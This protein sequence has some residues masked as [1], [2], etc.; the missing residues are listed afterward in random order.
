MECGIVTYA[1]ACREAAAYLP[2]VRRNDLAARLRDLAE[3][4]DM[5]GLADTDWQ[6]E[7]TE[8]TNIACHLTAPLSDP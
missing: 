8:F 4:L 2:D 5:L 3:Y 1:D 7:P 6:Q